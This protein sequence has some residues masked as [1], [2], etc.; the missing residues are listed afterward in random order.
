MSVANIGSYTVLASAVRHA[1]AICFEPVPATFARLEQN[2]RLN[3]L[4]DRVTA[5]NVGVEVISRA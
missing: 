3:Q 2:L 4:D 5:H 1:R